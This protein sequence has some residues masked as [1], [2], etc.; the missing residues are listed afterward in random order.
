VNTTGKIVTVAAVG[1]AA[2]LTYDYFASD[3]STGASGV[4]LVVSA[5][6]WIRSALPESTGGA[7]ARK[8]ATPYPGLQMTPLSYTQGSPGNTVVYAVSKL[9]DEV[10]GVGSGPIVSALASCE[11]T[12]TAGRL[13]CY[14]CNLFNMPISESDLAAGKKY[15]M[16]GNK[17][18]RDFLTGATSQVEGF[19]SC[20]LAFNEWLEQ[21]CRSAIEPMRRGQFNEFTI[22]WANAWGETVFKRDI[23]NGSVARST[24]KVRYDLLVSQHKANPLT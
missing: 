10:N 24:L 22:E 13:A 20:L 17:K 12:T 19:K 3:G 7:T 5:F 16:V 21:H 11:T 8:V 4:P 9:A 18:C 23:V 6:A 14:N 15:Y 1:G 2:Y